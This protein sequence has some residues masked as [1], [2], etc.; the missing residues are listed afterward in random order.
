MP[1]NSEACDLVCPVGGL[2]MCGGKAKSSIFEMHMCQDTHGDL[3]FQ[4]VNA[5]EMLVFFYDG[6]FMTGKLS[7][8][9]Q[10]NAEKVQE[11]AGEIGDADVTNLAQT[12]KVAAGELQ[13]FFDLKSDGCL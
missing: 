5:E 10:T 7:N 13:D 8:E 3:L 9:L 1:S 11:V 2:Q 4:A 12:A 6:A